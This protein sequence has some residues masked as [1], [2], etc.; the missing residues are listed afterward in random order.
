MKS[1]Q[2]KHCIF[3]DLP[4][5]KDFAH[6]GK[7]FTKTTT[8]TASRGGKSHFFKQ[9]S[10]VNPPKEF[11]AFS[12]LSLALAAR[13]SKD[14]NILSEFTLSDFSCLTCSYYDGG[15]CWLKETEISEDTACSE[16]W[17]KEV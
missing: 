4:V 16:H 6:E 13:S 15:F 2:T 9:T 14:A 12:S 5:G 11:T 10:L 17:N 3:S 7:I 1:F 8:K